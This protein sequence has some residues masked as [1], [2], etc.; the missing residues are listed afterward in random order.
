[1]D[2]GHKPEQVAAESRAQSQEREKSGFTCHVPR[3]KAVTGMRSR[4]HWRKESSSV[5]AAVAPAEELPHLLGLQTNPSRCH[6]TGMGPEALEQ[7]TG[8]ANS[9]KLP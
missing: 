3:P 7:R 9:L 1:M 5:F 6:N 8:A 4:N 2:T